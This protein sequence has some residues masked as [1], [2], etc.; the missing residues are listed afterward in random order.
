MND[1]STR[2][3]NQIFWIIILS[4]VIPFVFLISYGLVL[5][6][7]SIDQLLLVLKEPLLWTSVILFIVGV[8]F[9]FK[10]QLIK[11]LKEKD[12]EE[13]LLKKKYFGQWL[14]VFISICY[15]LSTYLYLHYIF[16]DIHKIHITA[17]FCVLFSLTGPVSFLILIY[18]KID[19][20][21]SDI[22]IRKDYYFIPI[23]TKIRITNIM[24]TCGSVSFLVLGVYMLLTQNINTE[25]YLVISVTEITYRLIVIAV[26]TAI[27]IIVP[28]YFLGKQL[29][30]QIQ[31]IEEYSYKIAN[32][33][34]REVLAR[35][36]SDELGLMVE[37]VNEMRNDLHEMMKGI[38]IASQ[39]IENVGS[40]LGNSSQNLARE[41][42][43]QVIH[44]SDMSNSIEQMTMNIEG[45]SSS[46]EQCDRLSSEVGVLAK[47]TYQVVM[48]NVKAIEEITLKVK[49]INE[50]AS[51]TNLLAINATIEAAS[52][53]DHG[54]GFAVVAKEVRVLAEKSKIS[55]KDI[56]EL[57]ALCL[58]LVQKTEKAIDSLKPKAQTTS[59][60]SEQIS[61]VS[62][63][64]RNEGLV[65]S[66]KI[67]DLNTVAQSNAEISTNLSNQSKQLTQQVETLNYLIREIKI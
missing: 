58:N 50:I 48:D 21:F 12:D 8:P 55:A 37:A 6:W 13:L 49:G 34:L 36:S 39:K 23:A 4:Y 41:S 18:Q 59:E 47:D 44:T 67:H 26:I 46:A 30:T 43:I 42:Q 16:D 64:T 62:Q 40:I 52:A 9:F 15:A 65:I 20:I 33:D 10:A 22:K 2:Y 31:Q 63:I 25:G 45:N 19:L 28:M 24:T 3:I 56:N 51:Q 35:T 14:F 54:L 27:F 60:L 66:D 7:L 11:M 17:L 61:K 53:G 57:S 1:I 38:Q 5:T 29:T 32:G